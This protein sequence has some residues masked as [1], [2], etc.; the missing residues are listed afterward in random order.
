MVDD[1]TL[2]KKFDKIKKI[3]GIE[4]FDYIK[5][6]IDMDDK[7]SD[8]IIVIKVVVILITCIRKDGDKFYTQIVSEEAIVA[9]KNIK[10]ERRLI[11]L[12]FIMRL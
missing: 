7:L 1:D 11:R 6:L 5:I 9:L 8:D 12:L 10:K 4:K 3:I 2:N